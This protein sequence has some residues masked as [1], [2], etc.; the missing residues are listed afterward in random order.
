M[1]RP[2]KRCN[3]KASSAG[4]VLCDWRKQRFRVCKLEAVELPRFSRVAHCPSVYHC[5]PNTL[6]AKLHETFANCST[7]ALGPSSLWTMVQVMV[8]FVSSVGVR[9]GVGAI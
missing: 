4:G 5:K 3:A 8:A 7:G 6:T 2:Q 9:L 1:S